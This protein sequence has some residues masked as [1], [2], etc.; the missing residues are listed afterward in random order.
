[1]FKRV[2][3]SLVVFAVSLPVGSWIANRDGASAI[4]A[5]TTA[6]QATTT[7]EPRAV[8]VSPQETVLGPAVV[9]ADA[10][11]LSGS[12]IVVEFELAGLAPTGD[13]A[14]V[15]R[16]LGFGNELE[17]NPEDLDTLFVDSWYLVAGSDTIDGT[18]SNPAARAA[19]FEV[20]DGFDPA[21][22]EEVVVDSYSLLAPFSADIT[23]S[24]GNESAVV[25]PG[26]TARLLAVTEQA[27]TIVQIEMISERDFVLD[28]LRVS[29]IGPGWLSAVREAEGRPR[30]NL[31]HESPAAPDPILIRVEGATWIKVDQSVPVVL[32]EGQ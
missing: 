20:G 5:P 25:A 17:V 2:A 3:V 1:M 28:N 9:I 4:S 7:T 18:T 6:P 32:G 13:S 16:Q 14:V 22:I 31:N 19:R 23:L 10:P 24:V 12:Q 8:F 27:K 11:Y 15:L 30:W 29:G 21:T 26:I